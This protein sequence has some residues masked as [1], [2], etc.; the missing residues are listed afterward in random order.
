MNKVFTISVFIIFCIPMLTQGYTYSL[1]V[2]ALFTLIGLYCYVCLLP[3]QKEIW[4]TIGSNKLVTMFIVLVSFSFAWSDSTVYSLLEIY[5]FLI[6]SLFCLF[7]V[8]RYTPNEYLKLLLISL[9]ILSV[10]NLITSIIL[11]SFAVHPVGSEHSGH[12]KGLL[13]HKNT[14]GTVTLLSCI[15]N[16]SFLFKRNSL[17]MVHLSIIFVNF[18]LLIKSGSSTALILSVLICTILLFIFTYY[19]LNSFSLKQFIFWISGAVTLSI[20]CYVYINIDSFFGLFGKSSDLTGRTTIWTNLNDAMLQNW[21]FGYGYQGYWGKLDRVLSDSG[22]IIL[23][24]SHSGWRDLWLDVGFVGLALILVIILVTVYNLLVN[25]KLSD[26]TPYWLAT[27]GIL[28]FFPA[29]NITDSRFLN[30]IPIYWLL[31]LI[32]VTYVSVQTRIK[33]LK[34]DSLLLCN[35]KPGSMFAEDFVRST[36][37]FK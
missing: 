1:P 33:K 18:I 2:Y 17:K 11:P 13:G 29:Y 16:L 4:Q 25:I 15:L 14:L 34:V 9:S 3:K 28:I 20:A 31:F 19:K 27:L 32:S 30:S 36:N 12:W 26:N 37:I 10:V 5:K 8:T 22:G 35:K 6:I 7:V 21:W 23:T 24:S